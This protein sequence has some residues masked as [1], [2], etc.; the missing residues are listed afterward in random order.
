M[1][2]IDVFNWHYHYIRMVKVML[3]IRA[4][5]F[6]LLRQ[7]KTYSNQTFIEKQQ[8][9][10]NCKNNVYPENPSFII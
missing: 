2:N 5:F 1:L 3:F 4:Y 8:K 9:S 10:T 7:Q 6:A